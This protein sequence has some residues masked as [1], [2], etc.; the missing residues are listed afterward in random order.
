MHGTRENLSEGTQLEVAHGK[1]IY[2]AA[3]QIKMPIL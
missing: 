1:K 2:K 3:R